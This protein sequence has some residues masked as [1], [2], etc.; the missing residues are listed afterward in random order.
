[1]TSERIVTIAGLSLRIE[2][3]DEAR[4]AAI[5]RTLGAA[6]PGVAPAAITLRW[7][8]EPQP[9]PSRP[10]E[11]PHGS[12]RLWHVEGGVLL[13]RGDGLAALVTGDEIRIGG[14][15]EDLDIGFRRIV[16]PGLTFLLA[17]HGRLVLHAGA[18][19]REGR[20]LLLL[21]GSGSGKSTLAWAAARA[22]WEA[23]SDDHVALRPREGGGYEVCGIPRP[24]AVPTA[25]IDEPPEGARLLERAARSRWELAGT[26]LAEGWR[27]LLGVVLPAHG[28]SPEGAIQ[29]ADGVQVMRALIA[30]FVAA[31]DRELMR[32]YFPHAAALSRLPA[33]TIELGRQERTRLASAARWL[34]AAARGST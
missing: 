6:P 32:R 10:S 22:G 31:G 1:M 12:L 27:P 26:A 17:H 28:Q 29:P 9:T 19:A 23:L 24:L 18:V 15:C 16:E 7:Q 4:D 8:A 21:G 20:A 13:S 14:S 3:A 33:W 34:D 2:A 5:A 30:S 11:Y 25:V